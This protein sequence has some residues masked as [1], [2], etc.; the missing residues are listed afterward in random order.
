MP[1]FSKAISNGLGKFILR[2]EMLRPLPLL[3]E[4]DAVMAVQGAGQVTGPQPM[5]EIGDVRRFTHKGALAAFAGMDAP[6]F[7]SG[8]FDSR[9][10]R[11]SRRGSLRLRRP[12][13]Q[14]A[15]TILQHFSLWGL[16]T[17]WKVF[18]LRDMFCHCALL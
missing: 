17:Y 5:A 8:T 9:S 10:R 18:F 4:F 2:G 15:S 16:D 1:K 13:F 11:V 3:P 7:R 12:L 14:I 6:P